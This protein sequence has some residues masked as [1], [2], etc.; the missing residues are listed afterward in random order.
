MPDGGD[1]DGVYRHI[2]VHQPVEFEIFKSPAAHHGLKA[3]TGVEDPFPRCPGDN[4]RK[5]HRIEIDRAKRAFGADVL[6]QQNGKDQAQH[7]CDHDE[8]HAKDE[9]IAERGVPT[10]RGE[11]AFVL[12]EPFDFVFRQQS[13]PRQRNPSR[14]GNKA[15]NKDDHC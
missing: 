5:R 10:G 14:P 8:Q 4:H 7:H 15:V 9:Q 13:G 12:D 1:N 6:I 3:E 11:Q 2:R